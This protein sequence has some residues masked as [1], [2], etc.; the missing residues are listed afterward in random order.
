LNTLLSAF[1]LPIMLVIFFIASHQE[2]G[3]MATQSMDK[4]QEEQIAKVYN[5]VDQSLEQG[6]SS[7]AVIDD[8]VQRGLDTETAS[9][10]VSQT[11]QVRASS[12][13]RGGG[14]RR[15]GVGTMV[16]GVGLLLLGLIIT[17]VTYMMADVGESYMVM[18][19][20][21]VV[22][23]VMMVRGLFQFIVGR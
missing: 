9:K 2:E 3:T 4:H 8:L 23:G 7:Q 12:G 18:T 6:K 10:I 20:L 1:H 22:G 16:V 15:A 17:G 5:Y 11:E 13:S 19:G 14:R 21:F